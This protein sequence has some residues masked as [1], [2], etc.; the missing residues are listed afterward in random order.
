MLNQFRYSLLQ[1]S[2]LR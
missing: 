2:R 1:C